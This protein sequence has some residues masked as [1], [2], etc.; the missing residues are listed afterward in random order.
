MYDWVMKKSIVKENKELLYRK[1]RIT[2]RYSDELFVYTD[3]ISIFI[4]YFFNKKKTLFRYK[5]VI[6]SCTINKSICYI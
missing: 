1:E 4:I 6:F 2:Y 3:F 5:N